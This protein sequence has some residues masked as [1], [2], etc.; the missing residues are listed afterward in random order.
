[1][2]ENYEVV[3]VANG[4]TAAEMIR[5]FLQSEGI[6]AEIIGESAG[7]AYGLTVGPLGE[8]EIW[9]PASRKLEASAILSAMDK[10]DFIP[11]AEIDVN[12]E[13]EPEIDKNNEE[14][15]QGKN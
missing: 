3:Y 1:M 11:T 6:P 5:I 7:T 15:S 13:I 9:V 10:G 8:V 14:D 4:H 2:P 12:V